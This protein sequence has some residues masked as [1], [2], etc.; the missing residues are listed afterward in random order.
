MFLFSCD[1]NN[2]QHS[3]LLHVFPALPSAHGMSAVSRSKDKQ[4]PLLAKGLSSAP[5]PV[6]LCWDTHRAETRSKDPC[7]CMGESS[8]SPC[9]SHLR[10][11]GLAHVTPTSLP[12][13]PMGKQGFSCRN[14]PSSPQ[15]HKKTLLTSYVICVEYMQTNSKHA[16]EG[17]PAKDVPLCLHVAQTKEIS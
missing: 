1:V 3:T 8:V 14:S 12:M 6:W 16:Q 7:S 13:L 11:P 10:A 5:C 17:S 15:A 2:Y 9:T 4:V